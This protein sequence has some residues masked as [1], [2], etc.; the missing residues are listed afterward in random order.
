M[1]DRGGHAMQLAMRSS[2]FGRR[3]VDN[4]HFQ[5]V[6]SS[7]VTGITRERATSPL[8]TCF[9]RQSKSVAPVRGLG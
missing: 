8:P 9:V 7:F 4:A 3:V 5:A 2:R 1:A 6:D